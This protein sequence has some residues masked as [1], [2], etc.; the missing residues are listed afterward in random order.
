M[1]VEEEGVRDGY[2]APVCVYR[3]RGRCVSVY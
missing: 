2:I 1:V 3:V